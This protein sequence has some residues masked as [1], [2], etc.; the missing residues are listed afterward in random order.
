MN[1]ITNDRQ[2]VVSIVWFIY[3][4]SVFAFGTYSSIW[5]GTILGNDSP[6]WKIF[7]W[8]V[9]TNL[10]YLPGSFAGAFVSDWIG[11]RMCLIVGMTAQA[12]VGFIM[13]G[14]YEY[15]SLPK[16]VAGFVVVYG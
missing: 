1:N 9:V 14:C 4:F 15:L 2:L 12:V 8:N 13:S 7:G 11:P 16:N 3:D 10:F 6:L 5:L